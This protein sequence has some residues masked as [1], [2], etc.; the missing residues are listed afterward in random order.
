M[1]L[2]IAGVHP[3]AAPLAD[4]AGLFA[5][6]AAAENA[7]HVLV[8][9]GAGVAALAILVDHTQAFGVHALDQMRPGVEP[10][11]YQVSRL[12]ADALGCG[13]GLPACVGQ[14]ALLNGNALLEAGNKRGMLL[15]V[16]AGSL[17]LE[18]D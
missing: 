11:L 15:R 3:D 6:G 7:L 10:E 13:R 1:A 2:L 17:L 16:V 9:G 18:M 12:D 8:V 5:C 4:Q 14:A